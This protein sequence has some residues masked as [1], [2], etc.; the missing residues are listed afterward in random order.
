MNTFD[1]FFAPTMPEFKPAK[2]EYKGAFGAMDKIS[3]KIAE[4]IV[5]EYD[6]AFDGIVKSGGKKKK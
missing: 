4:G 2:K 6:K 5:K 3:D 1:L